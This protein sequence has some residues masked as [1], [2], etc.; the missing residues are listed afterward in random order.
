[1]LEGLRKLEEEEKVHREIDENKRNNY[2]QENTVVY[3]IYPIKFYSN[4]GLFNDSGTILKN[5]QSL[6]EFKSYVIDL[7]ER[8]NKFVDRKLFHEHQYIWHNETFKLWIEEEDDRVKERTGENISK[9][10]A[11]EIGRKMI[12]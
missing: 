2:P 7:L 10:E 3:C 11:K 6:I 8:I 9:L 12:Y 5:K 4:S 1:M